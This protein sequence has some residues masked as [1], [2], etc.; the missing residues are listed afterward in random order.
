MAEVSSVSNTN[1]TSANVSS[2]QQSKDTAEIFKTLLLSMLDESTSSIGDFSNL[3][4]SSDS[5]SSSLIGG[6]SGLTGSSNSMQTMLLMMMLMSKSGSSSGISSNLI[7]ALLGS[8]SSG[9]SSLSSSGLSSL[10]SSGL[11]G[12]GSTTLSTDIP[13][14]LLTSYLSQY[15]NA[16]KSSIPSASWLA[17][18][19]TITSQVG[20]RSASAYRAVINQFN[21]ESNERYR[22][23]KLGQDDTYC[24]IFAWDVSH[25]M[26]AEIPHYIN[27]STGEPAQSGS[28]NVQELDANSMND[29]LNTYGKQY[30]WVQ[31][32]AQ[33]AQTYANQGMPAVTSW[34]NPNG[35]GHMQVVSPSTDGTYNSARGVAIAQAGEHLYNYNYS[36]AVYS[37]NSLKNVQYFAH[38]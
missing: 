10:S 27:A 4:G 19:P 35:H 36:T 17:S 1:S 18:N 8:G 23:N 12:S 11:S 6:S 31:V 2:S 3:N 38:I 7:S 30:G 25:A 29:W 14:S 22:V 5:D 28:A 24:N 34:K 26:G 15:Q 9:L 13:A 20:E 37:A 33:Q 16:S 21:V 32:S